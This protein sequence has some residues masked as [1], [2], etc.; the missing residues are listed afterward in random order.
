MSLGPLYVLLGEVT[1]HVF[2]PFFNWVVCLPGVDSCEF[3]LYFLDQTLVQDTIGKYIFPYGCFPFH[4]V[5][6]FF[7]RGEAFKFDILPLVY[8][9]FLY[10]LSRGHIS[11]K[12][13]V[14]NI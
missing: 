12:I 9:I 6:V 1:V 4:F 5:D 8:L 13:A 11:E 3:F 7:S 2:C 14:W 10:L